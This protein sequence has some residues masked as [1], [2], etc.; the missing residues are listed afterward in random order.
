MDIV[1]RSFMLSRSGSWR[2]KS[3]TKRQPSPHSGHNFKTNIF[4][5]Y[6]FLSTQE[7]FLCIL[8][9]T[10][11]PPPLDPSQFFFVVVDNLISICFYKLETKVAKLDNHH[12]IIHSKKKNLKSTT[13]PQNPFVNRQRKIYKLALICEVWGTA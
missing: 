3:E 13:T 7:G 12:P 2:V 1:G 5:W 11:Y 8:Q 10:M 9:F 6:G 4:F